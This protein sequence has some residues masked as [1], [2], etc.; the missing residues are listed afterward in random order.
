M[1]LLYIPDERGSVFFL[2]GSPPAGPLSHLIRDLKKRGRRATSTITVAALRLVETSGYAIPVAHALP[3]L[4]AATEADTRGA[5][6]LAAW[7]YATRLAL[8]LVARGRI[9]PRF[10]DGDATQGMARWSVHLGADDDTA[11][12]ESLASALPYAAFALPVP[13]IAPRAGVRVTVHAAPVVLRHFLDAAADAVVRDAIKSERGAKPPAAALR[14][15]SWS[16]KW[17]KGLTG[18]D[19]RLQISS[20]DERSWLDRT[21]NWSDAVTIDDDDAQCALRLGLC[22]GEHFPLDISIVS[23]HLHEDSV[24]VLVR[25]V[26]IAA[27]L[28]TPVR[29]ALDNNI[30]RDASF[31]I[32]LDASEA[33]TFMTDAAPRLTAAGFQVMIPSVFTRTG[34]RRLRLRMKITS[35]ATSHPRRATVP[36]ILGDVCEFHWEAAIGDSTLTEA[37]LH[38]LAASHSPLVSWRGEWVIA[39]PKHIRAIQSLVGSRESIS[40]AEALQSA[41]L[42]EPVHPPEAIASDISNLALDV[43]TEGIVADLLAR[44]RRADDC[45]LDISALIGTLR[46]YQERGVRWLATMGELG[47]GGCL[48]DDMGLGKTVQ[49]LA[50]LLHVRARD[51]QDARPSLIVCPTS[52]V[53]NWEREAARFAPSLRIIPHYG[54]DRAKTTEALLGNM[55]IAGASGDAADGLAN[56]SAGVSCGTVVVTT[57][58]VLRRDSQLLRDIAWHV[59]VL[60]EAQHVKNSAAQV[61]EDARTLRA[62]QRFALTGTPI[63]N[64]LSDL[65]SILHA[66]TP[67]LLGTAIAFKRTYSTPIEKHGDEHAAERLKQVIAPFVLRRVK[68]DPA[69]IVDL[70]PKQEQEVVCTLTSEQ[71]GL[72]RAVVDDAMRIIETTAGIT[73][74]G[75]VLALI[76]ALK[77]ICN[78]PSQYLHDQGPLLGR[79]GKLARLG[80]MLEEAISEGDKAL[81]FTQ[82]REMGDRLVQYLQPHLNCPI[83]YLHGGTATKVRT[84]MVHDF[85]TH[86]AGPM[87][88]ILSLKA[89]G[90]GLNLTAANHVFHFDRWWNPAVEDQAT[91]RAHRI[92]QTRSVQVHKLVTAGTIEEKI[93][94]MLAHKRELAERVVGAGERWVTELG[95]AELRALF[96]LSGSATLV[97]ES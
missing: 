23:P 42:N 48:A 51:P 94:F 68:T 83:H 63:E 80:E 52:V 93:S 55:A 65:W 78:H 71:A 56:A 43:R 84:E 95:D 9:V 31:R 60:D 28:F 96:S 4:A 14:D 24:A 91:D 54:A 6:S 17:I 32:Q 25:M 11:R 90:T 8:D 72:Y 87:V 40:I 97:D 44:I 12:V 59:L 13:H 26:G 1:H 64:R 67:G 7:V 86:D 33:W 27:R 57:Y 75:H 47:L 20:A 81:V 2:W 76:T 36:G 18:K 50:L 34:E 22:D 53:G 29:R 70:P 35:R 39:N 38:E 82:F 49:I 69:I 30:N 3:L 15:A 10:G 62:A 16:G 92:G 45:A 61:S 19:T 73:R 66:T 74:K 85:Q 41:L 5:P 37:E 21:N 79:S 58:P 77:Q 46:P 89:G 88:F